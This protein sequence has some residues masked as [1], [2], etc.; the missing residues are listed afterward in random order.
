[1]EPA[2][3]VA[4]YCPGEPV[5]QAGEQDM[6]P[7]GLRWYRAAETRDRELA[8]RW[9]ATVGEPVIELSPA[10]TPAE[11]SPGAALQIVSW[12]TWIGGGD[13]L[14]MLDEELGLD[15]AIGASREPVAV[16]PFVLLLQEVWRH[17]EDL[18]DV[19]GGR[20]IPWTIDPGRATDEDPD[21]VE[22]ARRCRLALVYVPSARNGPDTGARPKEDKGNAILSNVPLIDPIAIDLPL[23]GG[24]KVAVAATVAAPAG[25]RVRV[26]T[27]HLDVASTLVRTVLSGNQTR[28]RQAMGLVDGLARAEED[29]YEPD[30]TVV[31]A[32][33][34]TWAGNEATLTRMRGAFPQ[35]PVWDGLGTRGSFP[36]DHMFFR[37][38]DASAFSVRAYERVADAYSSD[39]HARRMVVG[40]ERVE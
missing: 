36:T 31:G 34:N 16:E 5:L 13:L 20:M 10:S 12:N 29:A 3:P 27:A 1:M 33:M 39:H 38:A 19:A 21:I 32:D 18:P 35:S 6:G 2:V 9:C 37:S 30:A 11:W 28:V 24:R 40:H 26:V 23:E 17:S 7:S 8:A 22:V 14:R 4:S 25:R 15:C